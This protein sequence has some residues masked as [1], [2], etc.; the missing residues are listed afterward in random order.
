MKAKKLFAVLLVFAMA[1]IMSVSAFAQV[2]PPISPM[3]WSYF[4]NITAGLN[5]ES[6]RTYS[7]VG[8]ATANSASTQVTV[9]VS[10]QKY[11]SSGWTTQQSWTATHR[12]GAATSSL[13]TLSKGSWRTHTEAYAYDSNGNLLEEIGIDSSI[14]NIS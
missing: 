11:T 8:G 9:V 10:L 6:G 1:A 3:R 7:C 14:V 5:Q 2:N 4:S 12:T 13:C